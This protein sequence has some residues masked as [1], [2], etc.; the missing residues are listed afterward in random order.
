MHTLLIYRKPK[1]V[2]LAYLQRS[3]EGHRLVLVLD[4]MLLVLLATSG[5]GRSSMSGGGVE[6][7][8][9]KISNGDQRILTVNHLEEGTETPT[10]G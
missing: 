4:L 5:G 2:T 3:K 9:R 8:G 1:N 6:H 10:V 7:L